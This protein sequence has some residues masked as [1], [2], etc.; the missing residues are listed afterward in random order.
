MTWLR[1]DCPNCGLKLVDSRFDATFRMADLSERLCF[2]IPAALCTRCQ[3]LYLDADL[4]RLL[5]VPDGR[6]VFAIESDSVVRTRAR[7]ASE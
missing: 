1:E 4:I 7:S 2:G 6:C 5:D 3:Q